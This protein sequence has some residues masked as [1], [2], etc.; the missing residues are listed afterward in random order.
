VPRSTMYCRSRGV[1]AE[2]IDKRP[3]KLQDGVKID[4]WQDLQSGI[5]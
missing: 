5:M 4:A 3:A 2:N 1:E